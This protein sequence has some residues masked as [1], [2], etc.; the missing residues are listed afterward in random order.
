KPNNI[1]LDAQGEPHLADFGLAKLIEKDSTITKTMAVLGTPSYIS[2][3]QAAGKTKDLTVAADVYGLGAVL[4]EL[5]TRQPP[6]AGGT[7]LETIRQVLEKEPRRPSDF[8]PKVDRDLQTVCLK[9]LEKDPKRRYDSAAALAED[10]E[11]WRRREPISAR[12]SSAIEKAIKWVRR[13]PA[14]AGLIGSGLLA[15][16]TIAIGSVAMNV[17]ISR[18]NRE[19]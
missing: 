15:L 8:N 9:C 1:L 14:G 12:P 6:F 3:E 2:P 19:A 4:Y 17:R 16:L 13:H 11:R 7:T 5:L 10:L 18:A